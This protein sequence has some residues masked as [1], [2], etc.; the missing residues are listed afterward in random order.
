[1]SRFL[2]RSRRLR[3]RNTLNRRPAELSLKKGFDNGRS[4][5]TGAVKG[6]GCSK[7]IPFRIE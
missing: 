4:D 6:A 5:K 1:M 7:S 2:T 3:S